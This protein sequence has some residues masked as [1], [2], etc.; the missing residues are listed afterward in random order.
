ML[1]LCPVLLLLSRVVSAQSIAENPA[2]VST[3]AQPVETQTVQTTQ[4]QPRQP[5]PQIK[6]FKIDLSKG[7]VQQ[8]LQTKPC[9]IPLLSIKPSADRN[10]TMPNITPPPQIDKGMVV[11]PPAPTCANKVEPAEMLKVLPLPKK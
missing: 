8:L 6:E 7:T 10:F 4:P 1:K 11:Q 2:A 3:S 5:A 9:S